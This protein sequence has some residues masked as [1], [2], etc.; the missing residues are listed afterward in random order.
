MRCP[1]STTQNG[2][3]DG[4]GD[5]RHSAGGR[6][7]AGRS[8]NGLLEFSDARHACQLLD[9]PHEP[10]VAGWGGALGPVFFDF[11]PGIHYSQFQMAGVTGINTV[12]IY[13]PVKQG[14]EHDP[15]GA[16]CPSSG[17][18]NCPR[19]PRRLGASAPWTAPPMEAAMGGGARRRHIPGAD[20]RLDRKLAQRG[21]RSAC[22]PFGKRPRSQGGGPA[23]PVA[24][25][26]RA[27]LGR[28]S[29]REECA[30]F[31]AWLRH[32]K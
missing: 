7:H 13:N 6:L 8:G 21:T 22:G 17:S 27:C 18:R 25:A 19:R 14:Q 10:R 20:A 29:R 26:C 9:A 5:D 31:D 2:W 4:T 16:F 30:N 23:H 11:E 32:S 12:R 28:T 3:N 24:K 15:A 1:S